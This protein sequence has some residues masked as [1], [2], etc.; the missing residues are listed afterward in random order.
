MEIKIE[1]GKNYRIKGQS[2]YFARKYGTSNPKIIIEEALDYH[3]EFKP[4]SFLYI[5]RMLAEG[6][7]TDGNTYYG[8]I[9]G[10]GEFVHETELEII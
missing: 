6:L 10:L 8:H 5:G 9:D 1:S 7:P 3:K 4:P 2:K